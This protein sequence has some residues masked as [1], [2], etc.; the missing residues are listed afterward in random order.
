MTWPWVSRAFNDFVIDQLNAERR[1]N[2]RLYEQIG[3]L[4]Q[5][6]MTVHQRPETPVSTPSSGMVTAPPSIIDQVI[7]EQAPTDPR[8]RSHL[9]SYA[10]RLRR[11]GQSEND[12]AMA[13]TQWQTTEPERVD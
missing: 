4:G 5:Q 13:L 3:R 12:I 7:R 9:R 2:L 8:L 11:E 1:E 10:S 6:L